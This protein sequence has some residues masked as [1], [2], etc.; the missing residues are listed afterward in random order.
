MLRG[1]GGVDAD[2]VV[3]II[4]AVILIIG[5]VILTAV[6]VGVVAIAAAAVAVVDK[7]QDVGFVDDQVGCPG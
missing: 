2:T 4:A 3:K 5:A 6:V 7:A 1:R